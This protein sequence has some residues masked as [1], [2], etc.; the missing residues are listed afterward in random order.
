MHWPTQNPVPLP[1]YKTGNRSQ[2][3][4]CQHFAAVVCLVLQS[5]WVPKET[6]LETQKLSYFS[7]GQFFDNIKAA[8]RHFSNE[9]YF[10]ELF[11]N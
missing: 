11:S 9:L 4:H 1:L 5:T 7:Y 8:L 3:F 2:Y 10:N 6:A